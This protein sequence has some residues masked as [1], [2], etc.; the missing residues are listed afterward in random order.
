M[1]KAIVVVSFG[2]SYVQAECSCIRPVEEALK[3]AFPD[4]EIRRAY[5]SRIIMK[6]LRVQGTVID[7]EAEAIEKLRAEGYEEIIVAPTHIIHGIE[8]EMVQKAASACPVSEA[9]LDGEADLKWMAQLLGDLA[10]QQGRTLLMMGHGTEHAADITYAQLRE[11]LPEQVRLA[12]VEG[13]HSLQEQ[14]P[15]L[16]ALPEKKLCLAP[17]MLV[18]GDH[19]HNDMAG[20]EPD[21]WKSTL[22]ARGFD[23]Q[24]FMQG[25]GAME[26]VQRRFVE[27]VQK[28]IG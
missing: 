6:K 2:T 26:Q 5:T 20:D 15:E 9:L 12:C 25:L 7:S 23:V 24:I 28:V 18:A 22:E 17:L 8:Y 14:L 21:S 16:D 4:Y 27:K 19:A 13:A 3:R 1:K 11:M 10:A